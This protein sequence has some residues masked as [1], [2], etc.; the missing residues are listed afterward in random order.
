M[1]SDVRDDRVGEDRA[2]EQVTR[3]LGDDERHEHRAEHDEPQR[4]RSSWRT[5]QMLRSRSGTGLTSGANENVWVSPGSRVRRLEEH[6]DEHHDQQQEVDQAGLV[7]EVEARTAPRGRRSRP[8]RRR[9]AGTRTIP[10]ITAATS[11][12]TRVLGPSD[13]EAADRAVVC[14]AIRRDRDRRRAR[15]RPPTRTVDTSFGL[16]PTSR[17]RSGLLADALTVLPSVV[18]FRNRPARSAMIG[19]TSRMASC[20]PV[21][22]M[23]SESSYVVPIGVGNRAPA[24]RT[25]DRPS[26]IT[27]RVG[28][29]RSVATSTMTRGALNSRRMTMSSMIAPYSDADGER[30]DGAEPERDVVLDDEQREERR[31]RRGPCCR[32]RS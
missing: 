22:R 5:H 26:A 14:T 27:A 11:A 10:A 18:R 3:R 29:R 21:I 15:R 9:P 28:R 7:E 2:V 4:T 1:L 23:P 20:G 24:R 19:T 30:D 25:R 16:M 6:R 31:R 17:A 8:R 32:R 12:R 13:A